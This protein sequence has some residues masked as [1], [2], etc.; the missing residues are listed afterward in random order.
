MTQETETYP[1]ETGISG[2]D[3]NV[4]SIQIQDITSKSNNSNGFQW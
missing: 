1:Q 2:G 4:T 3:V